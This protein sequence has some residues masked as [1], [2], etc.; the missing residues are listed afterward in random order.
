MNNAYMLDFYIDVPIDE[1]LADL[2]AAARSAEEIKA[3]KLSALSSFIDPE[4][5]DDEISISDLR[6]DLWD[7]DWI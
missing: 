1:Y 4:D 5:F 6:L 2:E 7:L 3:D